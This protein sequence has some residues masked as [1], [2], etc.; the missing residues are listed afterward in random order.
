MAQDFYS[1]FSPF[2]AS[3]PEEE[4]LYP[5]QG[6]QFGGT[7]NFLLGAQ[8]TD[9][10]IDPTVLAGLGLGGGIVAAGTG[11]QAATSQVLS[12]F[13]QKIAAQDAARL[14][15]QNRPLLVG[16]PTTTQGVLAPETRLVQQTQLANPKQ[17]PSVRATG[18]APATTGQ[19][20]PSGGSAKPPIKIAEKVGQAR[21]PGTAGS[22]SA[23]KLSVPGASTISKLLS[24]GASFLFPEPLADSTVSGAYDR[25][26]EAG[27]VE[28]AKALGYAD[29][30]TEMAN[31][32]YQ[33]MLDRKDVP[34][35]SRLSDEPLTFTAPTGPSSAP[36]RAAELAAT[37]P[38]D[39]GLMGAPGVQGTGIPT[40]T[41]DIDGGSVTVPQALADQTFQGIG[42]APMSIEETRARLGGRTLNEYLN[43]PSGT[44]GVSGLRTDPQGRM[45]PAEFE[46]RADA[47]GDYERESAAR[48]ARL[49]AR[50]QQ[51]GE[52]I[53]ERDTRLAGERTTGPRT[54]GGYT[55]AQLRDV[56]GGGKA[57]RAAQMQAE[58]QGKQ[59]EAEYLQEQQ[60]AAQEAAYKQQQEILESELKQAV[61]DAEPSK[62][63]EAIDEA[64]DLVSA[65]TITPSQMN[66]AILQR[67]KYDPEV[68][69]SF[70]DI[71][72]K[73]TGFTED[74][75]AR[76]SKV[77]KANPQ[78]SREQVINKMKEQGKL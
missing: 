16:G 24:T 72:K 33:E 21:L 40:T 37:L 9:G 64:N 66:A 32:A 46:T 47:Y 50:M 10:G 69:S 39:S 60:M 59:A 1:P 70:D 54:Y 26:M 61:K 20:V 42:A 12:P 56:V 23:G 7:G 58:M 36:Q 68:L 53:T 27:D 51:P 14:A 73:D 45:I 15:A 6:M 49:A 13:A 78:S 38:D 30:F 29:P 71:A 17:L 43:A 63:Q 5:E 75:E 31:A 44:E 48:E 35:M 2:G 22:G 77:M 18:G 67:L 4:L 76:I 8:P 62:V 3:Q 19:I 25:L 11:G 65:G 28:R 52:T 34:R 41:L 55:T 74:Q 57:L